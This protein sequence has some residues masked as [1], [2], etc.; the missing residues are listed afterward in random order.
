M[1]ASACTRSMPGFDRFQLSAFRLPVELIT[2]K[3]SSPKRHEQDIKCCALVQR[4][5]IGFKSTIRARFTNVRCKCRVLNLAISF[6]F[7]GIAMT[8]YGCPV[9]YCDIMGPLNLC[10]PA[11]SNSQAKSNSQWSRVTS[12]KPVKMLN[13]F[14]LQPSNSCR[15]LHIAGCKLRF[16]SQRK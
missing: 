15:I 5:C 1:S 7:S 16:A 8:F 9:K 10:D 13:W 14:Q 4:T 11:C 2:L 6:T 12:H 3:Q